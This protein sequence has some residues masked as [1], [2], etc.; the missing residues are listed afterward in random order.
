VLEIAAAIRRHSDIPIVLFS[1][2]NPLVR[3]G[4]ERLSEDAA[5]RGIDGCLLTDLSVEEADRHVGVLRASGL[6][7]I[8]LAAP[9]STPERLQLIARYS[10]GFIYLISRTG[11]TGERESVA[12]T[13]EPLVRAC[14]AVTSLPL[15]AGFG[16]SRPE[17]AA[18]V[19]SLADAVVVGSAVMRTVEQNLQNPELEKEL[20]TL[21]RNLRQG[22]LLRAGK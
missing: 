9:T 8:F 17:H 21:A 6:D 22:F 4:F 19:G 18:A 10:S 7:T 3:Y 12:G 16:I 5:A 14:R 1:Y 2:M 15:A 11:I 20:E 13:L